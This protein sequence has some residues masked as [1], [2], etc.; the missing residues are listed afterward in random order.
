MAVQ[1]LSLLREKEEV[2]EMGMGGGEEG[3]VGACQGH[4]VVDVL[5]REELL[6]PVGSEL[7]RP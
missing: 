5:Q 4:R 7:S 1:C 2:R 6:Q 3:G